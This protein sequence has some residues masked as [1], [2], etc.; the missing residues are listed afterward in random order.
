MRPN[1]L[2]VAVSSGRIGYVY[3]TDGEVRDW[4]VSVVAS[5][6]VEKAQEKITKLFALYHPQLIVT[7]K[8]SPHSR[9]SGRTIDLIHTVA[10]LSDQSNAHHI[11]VERIQTYANKYLEIEELARKHP[12]LANWKPP[13]RK[14]WESED[15]RTSIWEALALVEAARDQ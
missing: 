11:S 14:L 2:G 6:S 15:R 3:M 13:K 10:D 12:V 9:K 1:T 8:L 7:E 5:R 4:G